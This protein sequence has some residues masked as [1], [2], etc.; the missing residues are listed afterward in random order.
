MRGSHASAALLMGTALLGSCK[1]HSGD[2]G[3]SGV[4]CQAFGGGNAIVQASPSTGGSV[5]DAPR[6]F[7][8][9]LSSYASYT[10]AGGSGTLTIRGTAQ[11]G[12]VRPAQEIAGVLLTLQ[13][14]Q[15]LQVN[16]TTYLGGV[17][18]DTGVV[19]AR[20]G[21]SDSCSANCSR[22]GQDSFTGLSTTKPYDAIEATIA[23]SGIAGSL[24]VRELCSR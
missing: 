2:D 5:S 12:I 17:Q 9:D 4:S 13:S 11:A 1:F 15:S 21:V 18:Q 20:A 24:P 10:P 16:I 7:D 8:G 23:V 19:Y 22:S 14:A 6:A 3:R